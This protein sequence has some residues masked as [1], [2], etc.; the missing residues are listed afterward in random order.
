MNR[1]TRSSLGDAV[2]VRDRIRRLDDLIDQFAG[3]AKRIGEQVQYEPVRRGTIS[4][5]VKANDLR[6]QVNNL[7]ASCEAGEAL[8]PVFRDLCGR[9]FIGAGGYRERN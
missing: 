4:L 8:H 7:A 5:R 2:P 6:E 3:E 9:M 1:S